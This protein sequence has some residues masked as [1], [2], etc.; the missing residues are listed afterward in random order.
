MTFSF[1][2]QDIQKR[3]GPESSLTGSTTLPLT[4]LASLENARPGDISFLGNKKYT[5]SVPACQA[6]LIILPADYTGSPAH[7]GQAYLRVPNPSL[8]LAHI[9]EDIERLHRSSPQPGIHPSAVIADDARIDPSASIGPGCVVESGTTIGARTQLQAQVFIGSNVTLGDDCLLKPKVTVAD[10][11][12]IGH[13]VTLHPGVIIGA[14]GFGY[15]TVDGVHRKV[16]QIGNVVIEDDVEI[17]SNTTIDRARFSSTR[18]G[19]GSKIDNLVQIGH[20]VEIGKGCIIVSQ[21]GISGSCVLEDYV[22]LAGQVG[23]AGHLRMARGTIVAAKSGVQ[24]S[25][26]PGQV[27]RGNPAIEAKLANKID[28]LRKRMPELFKRVASLEDSLKGHSPNPEAGS[29]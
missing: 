10:H 25:T 20:N 12:V 19:A 28:V 15:E 7:Q 23:L 27:L 2:L 29:D 1:T 4:G 21:C 24:R 9:C 17:G 3:A 18:I 8:L 26:Q 6:S 16:P 14:D 5:P 11:C 22:I 13:R